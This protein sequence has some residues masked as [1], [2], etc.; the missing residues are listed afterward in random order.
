MTETSNNMLIE[1]KSRWNDSVL[2]RDE[3]AKTLADAVQSAVASGANLRGA[4][5]RGADLNG[6]KITATAS[7]QFTGHGECGRQ[8]LALKTEKEI[9][10]FCG[11]FMGNVEELRKYIAD[12]SEKLRKTR[13]LALDTV[14]VLLDARNE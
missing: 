2:Y 9:R 10:L 12:G 4:D 3:K 7:V 6:A 8:L 11:C 13:T 1:I 5:L 14:L